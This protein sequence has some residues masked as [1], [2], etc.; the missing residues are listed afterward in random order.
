ML[1]DL[2]KHLK[3]TDC[4]IKKIGSKYAQK[5]IIFTG[6]LEKMTRAEAKKIAEDFGMKVVG[7]IS[8][9]TDFVIAGSDAG[10]KLKKAQD[11][12]LNILNEDQWL[13]MI[14]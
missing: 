14:K 11:L 7:S 5:T 2:E 9:K 13:E 12:H 3:I 6:T 8:S 4:E 10:S 1:F